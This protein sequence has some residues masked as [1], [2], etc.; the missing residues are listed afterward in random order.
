LQGRVRK[1]KVTERINRKAYHYFSQFVSEIIDVMWNTVMILNDY[2]TCVRWWSK[3][4]MATASAKDR[5]A[6]E[7]WQT[8]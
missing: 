4:E 7:I 6:T 3:S 1:S 8:V 5:D 2:I